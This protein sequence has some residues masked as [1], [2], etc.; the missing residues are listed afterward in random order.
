MHTV[1]RHLLETPSMLERMGNPT[2]CWWAGEMAQLVRT[3]P[4]TFLQRETYTYSV[5]QPF[6]SLIPTENIDPQEIFLY[7]R[8]DT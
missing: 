2:P 6:C 4:G 1:T 8:T 3:Q 5:T 7:E